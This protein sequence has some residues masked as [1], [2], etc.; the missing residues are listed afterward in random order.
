LAGST[1]FVVSG[2]IFGVS[3]IAETGKALDGTDAL[4]GADEGFGVGRDDTGT[5]LVTDVTLPPMDRPMELNIVISVLYH[6]I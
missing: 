6:R 3:P 5:A 4:I 1:G 2:L